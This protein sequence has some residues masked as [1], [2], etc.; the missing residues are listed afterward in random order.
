[1][2]KNK[3]LFLI[4]YSYFITYNTL[5]NRFLNTNNSHFNDE[6]KFNIYKILLTIISLHTT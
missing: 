2:L 3:F 1:M 5:I 6:N 4:F